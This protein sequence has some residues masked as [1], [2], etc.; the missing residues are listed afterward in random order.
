[1]RSP[2]SCRRAGCGAEEDL[3]G[4][5]VSGVYVVLLCPR[6]GAALAASPWLKMMVSVRARLEQRALVRL[7]ALHGPAADVAATDA[8]YEAVAEAEGKI[9]EAMDTWVARTDEQ[10]GSIC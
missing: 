5:G 6:H 10:E 2:A 9:R 3:S 4:Y 7:T 8:A 1:M